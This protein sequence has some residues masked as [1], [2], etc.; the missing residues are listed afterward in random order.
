[1]ALIS[2]IFVILIATLIGCALYYSSIIAFTIAINDRDST[3]AFYIA[4]AGIVHARALLSKV[5]KAQY[6]SVLIAG[7][8]KP[9]TGD[10]LSTPPVTGLWTAAN[11]IP[12]GNAT[13][14]GF[15]NFGAGGTGRYWMAVK[16]D[17]GS[18]ESNKIDSNGT[19]I[20]IST[21]HGRDGSTATIEATLRTSITETPAMLVNSKLTISGNMQLKGTHGAVHSNDTLDFDGNP[22]AQQYFSS[23]A[24]I[25]DAGNSKGGDCNSGGVN[26][27]NQ[28]VITPPLYNIRND[29]YDKADYVL[30]AVGTKAGNVYNK[31]GQLV[32]SSSAQ[33]IDWISNGSKWSWNAAGSKWVHNGNTIVNGTYYSEANI[34]IIDN[35]GTATAPAQVSL[36]AEGFINLPG[37]PY[38]RP[39]YQNYSM[40]AG[41]D[42]RI[43]GNAGTG[44]V[45]FEGILYAHHQIDFSGNPGIRGLVIAANQGDTNSPGCGCNLIPLLTSGFMRVNGNP[46]ITY[47]GGLLNGGGQIEMISWREVRY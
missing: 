39:H 45:N 8:T 35:F 30:G 20:I 47:N 31:N 15:L 37:N 3:E 14:G 43:G 4:D 9:G 28:P 5:P 41:T 11:G 32:H 34:E 21:G 27:A 44:G 19:L 33:G 7:D 25:V 2:A 17:N 12:A 40:M 18:G 29:F 10:E 24:T 22:C 13:A 46:V 1:M 26:R 36:F 38:M 16:N 42:L 6:S 23:S